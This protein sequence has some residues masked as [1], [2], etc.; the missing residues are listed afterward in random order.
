MD[1]DGCRVS[2]AIALALTLIAE[3]NPELARFLGK[4]IETADTYRTLRR[5]RRILRA[6]RGMQRRRHL[7][8]E[9]T[10]ATRHKMVVAA[11]FRFR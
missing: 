9:E 3:Q 5:H 8:E 7:A 1:K 6:N 10:V 4:T 2:G 11:L